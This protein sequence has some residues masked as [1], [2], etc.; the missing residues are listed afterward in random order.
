VSRQIEGCAGI[1]NWLAVANN[2]SEQFWTGLNGV[3]RFAVIQDGA[4]RAVCEAAPPGSGPR[5]C[6]FYSPVGISDDLTEYVYF[7]YTPTRLIIF[8]RSEDRWMP[9]RDT[10]V[11]NNN[12]ILAQPGAGVPIG[13]PALYASRSPVADVSRLA[14]GQCA[15]FTKGAGADDT[16][17]L[18][19]ACD[20]VARLDVNPD[21]IFW[22]APFTVKSATNGQQHTCAAATE[23][24]LTLCIMPR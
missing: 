4:P 1:Q 14:P 24:R 6:W 19:Q 9:L 2:P 23:G 12:P 16:L 3:T 18:P 10:A 8:N 22:S 17:D 15:L 21:L 20:V 5:Q 13:D 11:L 7:A